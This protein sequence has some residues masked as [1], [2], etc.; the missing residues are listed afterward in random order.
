MKKREF[1][2]NELMVPNFIESMG[3]TDVFYELDIAGN[4]ELTFEMSRTDNFCIKNVDKKKTDI[5]YFN[6]SKKLSMWK[7]VDHIIFEHLGEKQW[8]IH[9]IEMKS[10]VNADK[11]VEVKGKFRASY[12]LVQGI[13]AMLE[14]NIVETLMYTTYEHVDMKHD[15]TLPSARRIRSGRRIVRPEDEWSGGQFELN[16]GE[17]VPFQHIPIQMTRN[18]QDVLVGRYKSF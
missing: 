10:S 6:A 7:R 5:L 12:L 1:I 9:L 15:L 11:W 3:A 16:F 2:I 18:S 13:A 17:G 8:R 14:M 4:S